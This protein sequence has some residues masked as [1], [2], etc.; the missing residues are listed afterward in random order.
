MMGCCEFSG[1][2]KFKDSKGAT[3]PIRL[4]ECFDAVRKLKGLS[5]QEKQ[6]IIKQVNECSC[7]CHQDCHHVMCQEKL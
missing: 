2:F 6:R 4:E 5:E 3:D 7:P 1:M